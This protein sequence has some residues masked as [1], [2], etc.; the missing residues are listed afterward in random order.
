MRNRH[1]SRLSR[2][3]A[4]GAA[5][6]D[7][8]AW[9][10][11]ACEIACARADVDGAAITLRSS[12]GTPRP[13]GASDAWTSGLEELQY[14][15]GEGPADLAF[16]TLE[17]ELVADLRAEERWPGFTPAA[18]ARGAGAVFAFPLRR[19]GVPLGT[20]NLYRRDAG[21]LSPDAVT[22]AAGIGELAV[23]ALLT[24]TA[25]TP[26]PA[27]QA[28]PDDYDDVN[29][30]AGVLAA[31]L[32]VEVAEA[33]LRLRAHAFSQDAS[34]LDVARAVVDGTLDRDR[35]RD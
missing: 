7:F 25:T 16:R 19:G 28:V 17:P 6:R 24:G 9:A 21:A 23:A 20:M 10:R 29:V 4:T 8:S 12:R 32:H 35:F 11:L 30:A 34:L 27:W 15:V 3:L 18:T 2:L 14:T 5:G 26:A 31:E 1:R 22:S 33:L 13:A